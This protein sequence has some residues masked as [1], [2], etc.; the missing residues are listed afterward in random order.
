MI[1][2]S[3]G[4]G[5]EK[6]NLPSVLEHWTLREYVE[7]ALLCAAT[8]PSRRRNLQ[9]VLLW[10]EERESMEAFDF[11]FGPMKVGWLA[12]VDAHRQDFPCVQPPGLEESVAGDR[13]LLQGASEHGV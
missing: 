9:S 7:L 8:G 2:S 13:W 4:V 11:A 3:P 12:K 10:L 1:F 5:V 6:A